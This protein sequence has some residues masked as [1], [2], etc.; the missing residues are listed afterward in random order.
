MKAERWP[1]DFDA[2]RRGDRLS[3]EQVERA[4]A[5]PRDSRAYA[6]KAMRL[7][8]TISR[9]FA[10]VDG[11]N[12]AVV[13]VKDAL[14]ILTHAEQAEYA[15]R[16][17]RSEVSAT[18]RVIGLGHSVDAAQLTVEQ[19]EKHDR[20]CIRSSWLEQQM[21]KPPPPMLTK[22]QPKA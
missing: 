22:E 9:H 4:V 2:L 21:R 18:V 15:R 12:V 16:R 7:A 8:K 10:E 3:P 20:W 13:F 11:D 19:R 17:L 5:V 1:L 14:H 6:L